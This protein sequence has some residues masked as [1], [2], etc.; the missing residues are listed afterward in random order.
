MKKWGLITA[1]AVSM[2]TTAFVGNAAS[3]QIEKANDPLCLMEF[4]G[5]IIR[6]DLQR[7]N[8]LADEIL[9]GSDGETTWKNTICL[10]SPGGDLTEGTAIAGEIYK[11]GITT[12][13]R[14]GESC[15]SAC[16]IMF[17]MG[18]AQG[19]EMGWPSR[20]MHKNARLG[21]HRP[22][23]AVD[24]DEKI[25]VRVLAVSYDEAQKALLQI[26]NLADSPSGPLTTR[27]MMKPYLVQ[28]MIAHVGND[29]FMIDDVN[30]AGRFDIEVF[31]Y[32]EPKVIDA[33]TAFMACDNAFYWESRLLEQNSIDYLHKAYTDKEAVERQ[34]KPLNSPYGQNFH[35]VSNDAGYADAEC[36]VRFYKDKLSVC[37]TNDTYDIKLGRE[38]CDPEMEYGV[39][40]SVPKIALWPAY[41]K[42]ASLPDEQ[43]AVSVQAGPR[44]RCVVK[45]EENSVIDDEICV[46][47]PGTT[48]NGF[49]NVDFTWPSGSKTVI[50]IGKTALKIN[51]DPAQRKN[52]A[53]STCFLN[54]RTKKWFC[55]TKLTEKDG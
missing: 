53:D 22:Y 42:L 14:D 18:I 13:I 9:P 41:A 29:F 10:N 43:S 19:G 24:S 7:F 20:K 11:R 5:E 55:A 12:V 6:G 8:M 51:G 25:S 49:L 27:P 28:A 47:G 48:A 33:K 26:F 40:N 2:V 31:G 39:L 34:A 54:E 30:R 52:E 17:M 4:N 15:Y 38:V 45:S 32:Q 23:L 35:V 37:G 36:N 16:A 21:F 46:Q 44:Y 50:S 1:I 3:A